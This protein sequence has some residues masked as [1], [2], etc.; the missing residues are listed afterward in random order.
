M[1]LFP[2]IIQIETTI[3]CNSECVFCP[4]NE[5]TRRP[6]YME[7]WVWQKIV[8]ESRGR[9]IIY[10][11]FLINEP[12]VD[13]RMPDIIRYIKE[14]N[15]ARVELNSNGHMVKSTDIAGVLKAGLDYI[16]FSVDGFTQS[17]YEKSGRGGSLKKIVSNI[18]DFIDV[19][20]KQGSDCFVEVRMIDLECN[21]AEQKDYLEFW[22][23]HADKASITD[24]YSWP[25]TGQTEPFKAPCPKI[26]TELFFMVNGNAALCCWDTHEKGII[27]NVKEL[28][29]EE[30]WLGEVNQ[31]YRSLLNKGERDK[32]LLC[33]KCDAYEKYDFSNWQGY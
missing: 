5:V 2:E 1:V 21:K 15:T 16:R 6:K 27:G 10:R 4:Q 20:K 22:N 14:D 26:R 32:I 11:P 12:F 13:T 17:S 7:D 30:I 24:L 31:K 29:I 33:S 18:L 8:D 19:K 23:K 3:L 25:W 9:G 28:T